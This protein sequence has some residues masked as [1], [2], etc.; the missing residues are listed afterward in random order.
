MELKNWKT[1]TNEFL[2][3]FDFFFSVLLLF[4][5]FSHYNKIKL[6]AGFNHIMA[7]E[8]ETKIKKTENLFENV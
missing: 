1:R 4:T 5:L 8:T 7:R 2:F 3:I 6:Y